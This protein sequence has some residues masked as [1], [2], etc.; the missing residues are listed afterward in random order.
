[1]E[2]QGMYVDGLFEVPEVRTIVPSHLVR[3]GTTSA[4]DA[5]FGM[6]AGAN[7]VVLLLRDFSGV[8]VTGFSNNTAWYM[9]IKDAIKQR[10]VDLGEVAI[11]E[12]LGF[13]FGRVRPEYEPLCKK[14]TRFPQRIY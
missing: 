1:M 11:F 4:Y 2:Q 14:E 13:T 3:S 12:Q 9:D 10:L 7:A 5:N 6:V 8:T